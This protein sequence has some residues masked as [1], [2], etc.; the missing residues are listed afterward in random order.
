MKIKHVGLITTTLVIIVG[1]AITSPLFSSHNE[2]V[3]KQRVMLSFSISENNDV[4]TW[5]QS[6]ASILNKNNIGASIFL[7]GK[8]AEQYPQVVSYFGDKVDMGSQT[9][10]NL[11]LNEISDYS[12]KLQ[13]VKDGKSAVDNAGNIDTRIFRAPFGAT[14]Q[15]IYS[16]L[17]RS[18]ILVD[19]SYEE[20]FNIYR[21]G[22]FV[23]YD[24]T[25]YDVR[26]YPPEFFSQL[27]ET[28][29]PAIIFIDN[30][31]PISGIADLISTLER[32]G[33]ELVNA[34]ELTGLSLSSYGGQLFTHDN[35]N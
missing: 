10:S 20:Q 8:L 30:S 28:G 18:G 32:Q 3:A 29:K 24:A 14:D 17:S 5:C 34:S 12:V 25:T 11:D 31:Y 26:D 13:E 4:T 15:D 7:V 22:Q 27:P 21:Y 9:Y 35:T 19:F 1:F 16:L 2:T 23:K 33:L 6:L